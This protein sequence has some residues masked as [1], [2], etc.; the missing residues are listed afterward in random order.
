MKF[1]KTIPT[2]LI[3]TILLG[4]SALIGVFAKNEKQQEQDLVFSD[5][6]ILAGF[7]DLEL[8]ATKMAS[9]AEFME[10]ITSMND[11]KTA[12]VVMECFSNPEQ[13]NN[14]LANMSDPSKM[15]NAL[16]QFMNPQ[17]YANWMAASM[18]PQ[19]YQPMYTYM[20]PAF[21]MQ[22]MTAS[23]NPA[24]YQPMYKMMN[25]AWQQ[26]SMAW[27]ANPGNYQQILGAAYQDQAPV[28]DTVK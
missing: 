21:Y 14:W 16:T 23:M 24:F 27:I 11:P 7:T 17:I 25:P 2:I 15:T 5:C 10:L 6:N 4:G 18:N 3:G 8:M 20:N 26:E 9:P 22:W 12:Q 13:W 19:T 1:S 28:T